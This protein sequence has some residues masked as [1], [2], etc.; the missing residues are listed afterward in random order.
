MSTFR[1]NY[2]IVLIGVS[3]H[4]VP[5]QHRVAV[6][7]V[8]EET[9]CHLYVTLVRM[10]R[11]TYCPTHPVAVFHFSHPDGFG[12]VWVFHY[13]GV[14]G[15]LAGCPVVVEYIPFHSARNPCAEHSHIGRLY[16]GLA[17]ENLIPVSLV[18]GIEQTASD[19]RK[20]ADFHIVVLQVQ[21][22]MGGVHF[23][24]GRIV[25]HSI[26][27]DTPFRPLVCEVPFK[28]RSFFRS[29]HPVGGKVNGTLPSFHRSVLGRQPRRCHE[30]GQCGC[31]YSVHQF[32]FFANLSFRICTA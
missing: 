30:Q 29:R 32:Q 14:Y 2:L 27:I 17:I 7:A 4:I 22:T 5:V 9:A 20:D 1:E 13:P 28:Q 25:I 26:G 6:L 21:G 24:S 16:D 11:H 19:V 23:L 8:V 31:E 12:P 18:G 10:Q 15:V 3:G